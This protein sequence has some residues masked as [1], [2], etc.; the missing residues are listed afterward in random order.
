MV[1]AIDGPSGAGKSTVSRR[2]AAEL[3]FSYLD[4]G[5][6]YRAVALGASLAGWERE[7]ADEAVAAQLT[8]LEISVRLE[9]G[10]FLVLLD[11][12]EVEP[13]IRNE[14]IGGL[15]S[16]LSAMA[17]VREFLLELQRQAGRQGD[18][19]AEG[20]DMGSVVFPEAEV[21]FFLSASEE[22]RAHRRWL[23]LRGAQPDL[24]E[25]QVLADMRQRDKRDSKRDI[26]PLAPARDALV[27]D[28]SDMNIDQVVE[29]MLQ[30]VRERQSLQ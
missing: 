28:S 30:K 19:V 15:A 3:G 22:A 27:V 6:L 5:A 7:T 29:F 24:E 1:V 10:G 25:S 16:R 26:S 12:G 18:L 13:F 20:R 14:R 4:T 21:K 2:L 11:G 23:E 17:P 8:R 9:R